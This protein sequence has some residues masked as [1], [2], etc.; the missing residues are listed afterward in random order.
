VQLPDNGVILS[1]LL[2]FIFPVATVL[3]PTLEEIM[4]LLSVAQKYEM[5]SVLSHIRNCA[6][7]K[8]PPFICPENAFHAYTLSET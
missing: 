1:T 6:A 5:A 2:T 7:S 8:D 4:Q 3:L